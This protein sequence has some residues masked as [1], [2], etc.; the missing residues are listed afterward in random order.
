MVRLFELAMSLPEQAEGT[1]K[2]L[3]KLR[4][5][6]LQAPI[7]SGLQVFLLACQSLNSLSSPGAYEVG[8][9]LFYQSEVV[10]SMPL[11]RLLQ[12]TTLLQTCQ[13]VLPDSF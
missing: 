2:P 6:L 10:V 5:S 13:G 8:L 7:E 1:A 11:L 3:R 9:D 4:S 12:L